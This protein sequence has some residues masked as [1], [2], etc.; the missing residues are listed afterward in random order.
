M[1]ND[2]RPLRR[3]RG[4]RYFLNLAIVAFVSFWLLT[5]ILATVNGTY[6]FAHPRRVGVGVEPQFA[7]PY[8]NVAFQTGDGL[9]LRGWYVP[10]VNGATIIFTHGIDNNR[11]GIRAHATPLI[12]AGYGALLFDLRAQGESDGDTLVYDGRD[13]IAAVDYLQSRD[14]VDGDRIGA[15]GFSLG[16]MIVVQAAAVEPDIKAVF[17]DG[18][19]PVAFADTPTPQSLSDWVYYPVDFVFW[20]VLGLRTGV[21]PLS[22]T[23]MIAKIAPRPLY[24]VGTSGFEGRTVEKIYAAAGEPKTLWMIPETIHGGGIFVQRDEYVERMVSF[25]DAALTD[26]SQAG[27]D[28]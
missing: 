27:S 2:D 25:F 22:M 18:P 21:T 13:V 17:V 24:V 26:T 19:G 11:T 15:F 1:S 9:T 10:S 7:R 23:E 3:K 14:D 28:E 16:A 12:E 4:C 6:T 8:E 5:Y 20:P